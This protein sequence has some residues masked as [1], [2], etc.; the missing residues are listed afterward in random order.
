MEMNLKFWKPA[1][2]L[3]ESRP[4]AKIVDQ[5]KEEGRTKLKFHPLNLAKKSNRK[6]RV[7]KASVPLSNL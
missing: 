7:G 5:C 4:I 3:I 2:A 6:A 1:Q